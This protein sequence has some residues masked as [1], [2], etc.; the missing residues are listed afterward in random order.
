MQGLSPEAAPPVR[1]WSCSAN[2]LA[3]FLGCK[4]ETIAAIARRL[5]IK[6]RKKYLRHGV[7]PYT[8]EQAERIMAEF[9][10]TTGKRLLS[11]RESASGAAS[12]FSWPSAEP[13]A[14]ESDSPGT[15]S[16]ET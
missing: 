2:E 14:P 5:G 1:R 16:T 8:R 12:S 9:Y 4:A 11:K 3:R 13:T 10:S 7:D 15:R 6:R